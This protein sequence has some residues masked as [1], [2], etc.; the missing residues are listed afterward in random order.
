[1][2]LCC[3]DLVVKLLRMVQ[4]VCVQISVLVSLAELYPAPAMCYF[5]NIIK[6]LQYFISVNYREKNDRNI[7]QY[8]PCSFVR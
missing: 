4:K 5:S 3:S 6:M 8:T 1:M 2:L 7:L